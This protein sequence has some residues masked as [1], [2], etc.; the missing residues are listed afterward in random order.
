MGKK[1]P[2]FEELLEEL[3]AL[4]ERLESGELTLD[5]ALECYEQ[6][7][8]KYK[9]CREIL[10]EAEKKVQILVKDL[11]GNLAAQAFEEGPPEGQ[12]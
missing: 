8:Q 1:Q 11:A 9:V 4:V 3:Q 12:P 5:E 10:D 2:K 6:G 7:I